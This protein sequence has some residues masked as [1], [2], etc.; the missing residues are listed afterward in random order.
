[1]N[2][3]T[4]NL[5]IINKYLSLSF[6]LLALIFL[7]NSFAQNIKNN[8]EESTPSGVTYIDE[9]SDSPKFSPIATVQILNKTTAK[10]LMIDLKV[11]QKINLGAITIKA[12]KCWQ[13]PLEQKP[14]TKI[15]LE[16]FENKSTDSNIDEVQNSRIFYGWIFASSPSIS[17]V[18][19]PIYDI[20]AIA[21]KN[22]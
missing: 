21:C 1:M 2:R 22:K 7:Q 15:L 14:E 8:E 12:Y 9:V 4:K 13:A 6:I 11:G 17:G 18:Q 5:S 3:I 19:H 16:V 20:V 10:N